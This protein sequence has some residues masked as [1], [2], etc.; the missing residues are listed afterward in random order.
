[1]FLR[2]VDEWSERCKPAEVA[3]KVKFFFRMY[4]INRH[5]TTTLT[6]AYHAGA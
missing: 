1:M 4:A 3:D 6:P 5:K 2:L